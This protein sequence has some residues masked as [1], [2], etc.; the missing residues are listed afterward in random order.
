MTEIEVRDIILGIQITPPS[1]ERQQLAVDL[2]RDAITAVT[3]QTRTKTGELSVIQ[4]LSPYEQT[5]FQSKT[6]W[7]NN[8]LQT[9]ALPYRISRIQV[10]I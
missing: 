8:A 1:E 5:Q 2:E 6:D 10:P 7:I 3:T 4:T 9:S